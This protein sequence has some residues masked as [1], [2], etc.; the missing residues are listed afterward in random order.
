MRLQCFCRECQYITGGDSLLA[1]GVPSD[2]FRI[3]RGSPKAFT[4]DDI[5]GAVTREFCPDCGTHVTTRAMAGLVIIKVGTLDD[6]GVF[7]G[8]S[9]AVYTCDKQPYHRLADSV[10]S[11]E[12]LPQ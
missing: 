6:P 2:G 12:K 4:R 5:E 8:P 1:M 3:T 7:E 9:M 11:F 10:P